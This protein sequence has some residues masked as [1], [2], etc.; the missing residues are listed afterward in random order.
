MSFNK[1]L[2]WSNN[3]YNKWYGKLSNYIDI[4][5]LIDKIL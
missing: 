2:R 1:K 4:V 5:G 3:G